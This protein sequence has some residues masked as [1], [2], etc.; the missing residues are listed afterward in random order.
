VKIIQF[1]IPAPGELI[2]LTDTGQLFERY[3]D[4]KDF[5]SGPNHR[6]RWL[7]RALELPELPAPQPE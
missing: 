6:P 7:W 5:N 1:C 4:L 2:A 3:R